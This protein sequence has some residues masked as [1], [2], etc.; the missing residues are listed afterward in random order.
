MNPDPHS[1]SIQEMDKALLGAPNTSDTVTGGKTLE[2]S[3]YDK[4]NMLSFQ[5]FYFLKYFFFI[6]PASS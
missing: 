1:S 4:V 6:D 3:E 5:A 2:L